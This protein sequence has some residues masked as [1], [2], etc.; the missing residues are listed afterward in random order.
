[1]K[2]DT[3][4]RATEPNLN[5]KLYLQDAYVHPVF[6]G[7]MEFERPSVVD[8]EEN[9]PLVATKRTIHRE[10]KQGFQEDSSEEIMGIS[11]V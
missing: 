8:E 5:L 7:S 2:K 9:S 11:A 3:L 10:G 1:M 4:E 6:R